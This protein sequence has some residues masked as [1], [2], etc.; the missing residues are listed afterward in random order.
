MKVRLHK[1][2]RTY[3][4]RASGDQWTMASDLVLPRECNGE[5]DGDAAIKIGFDL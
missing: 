2:L 1:S 3:Q 5:G 4:T